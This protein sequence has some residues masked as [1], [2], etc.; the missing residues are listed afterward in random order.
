MH[1][2]KKNSS[3]EYFSFSFSDNFDLMVFLTAF[4]REICTFSLESFQ[5][6]IKAD[7]VISILV[8]VFRLIM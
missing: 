3:L 7:I 5:A 6:L 2:S 4:N 8:S 1:F